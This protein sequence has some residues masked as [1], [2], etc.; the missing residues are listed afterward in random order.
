[1]N[2]VFIILTT[3]TTIV[4]SNI[5]NKNKQ[6]SLFFYFTIH[7]K[8]QQFTSQMLLQFISDTDI[9][10]GTP[11][12]NKTI[13]FV[14]N[15]F[16]SFFLDKEAEKKASPNTTYD[17]LSS[18]SFQYVSQISYGFFEEILHKGCISIDKMSFGSI[19]LDEFYFFLANQ[20]SQEQNYSIIG[21]GVD[22][23]QN[24]FPSFI[25]QLNNKGII[26]ARQYTIEFYNDSKGRILFGQDD[27]DDDSINHKHI[28]KLNISNLIS[29]VVHYYTA[30]KI[31]IGEEEE[32]NIIARHADIIFDESFGFIQLGI[33]MK[34]YVIDSYLIDLN[35]IEETID[36]NHYRNKIS[37]YA[38]FICDRRRIKERLDKN[39][40]KDL[41]FSFDGNNLTFRKEELFADYSS[42]KMRFMIIIIE[43]DVDPQ[44]VIGWP[45]L[46]QYRIVH[47]YDEKTITLYSNERIIK[48]LNSNTITQHNS[49]IL[50]YLLLWSSIGIIIGIV[51][52]V[53]AFIKIKYYKIHIHTQG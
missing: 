16:L 20:W 32:S 18:S 43:R 41:V 12:I 10:I 51:I 33:G 27:D 29:P 4:C 14:P 30:D 21:L 23:R 49:I 28:L 38:H 26:N 47:D 37:V 39:S 7:P 24:N 5:L 8:T 17:H 13:Q 50:F 52:N 53:I 42:D 48:Y 45:I 2:A 11:L 35:C 40:L 44:W 6:H 19:E 36:V 9:L 25:K 15:S 34:Q 31:Y 46:K 1:M 22:F 3:I